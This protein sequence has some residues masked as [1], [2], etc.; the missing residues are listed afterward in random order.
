MNDINERDIM[1]KGSLQY[2]LDKRDDLEW[3]E[4]REGQK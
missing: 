2:I 3:E 1:E 4:G